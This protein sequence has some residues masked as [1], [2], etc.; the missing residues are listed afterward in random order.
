LDTTP[1]SDPNDD[2]LFR[3]DDTLKF[4]TTSDLV[5]AKNINIKKN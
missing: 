5:Y 4:I 2:M 1:P 3:S